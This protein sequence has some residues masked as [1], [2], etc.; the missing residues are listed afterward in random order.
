MMFPG[1]GLSGTDEPIDQTGA[2]M[3]MDLLVNGAQMILNSP[4]ADK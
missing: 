4:V 3:H 1:Y 2:V